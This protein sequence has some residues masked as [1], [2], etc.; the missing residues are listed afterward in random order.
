[1]PFEIEG[2]RL[3]LKG[4]DANFQIS[5]HIPQAM[6]SFVKGLFQSEEIVIADKVSKVVFTVKSV[7]SLP[8]PLLQYKESEIINI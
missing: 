6:E 3:K 7:E 1:M 4:N 8:N 5:F 2:D